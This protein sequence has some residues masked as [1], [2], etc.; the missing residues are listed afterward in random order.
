MEP[1]FLLSWNY[2]NPFNPETAI[3]YD[4]PKTGNVRVHVYAITGQLVRTLMDEEHVAGTYSVTWDGADDDGRDVA[5]SVYLCR[6]EA[7]EFRT[8]RKMALTR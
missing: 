3:S 2:P 7:G 6:M 8:V 4:V 5:S 1:V